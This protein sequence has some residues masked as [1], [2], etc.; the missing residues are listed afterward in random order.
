MRK[1]KIIMTMLIAA[2]SMPVM[3]QSEGGLLLEA[4]AEKKINKKLSMGVEGELRLRN[5]FK[6]VDRWSVGIGAR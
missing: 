1:Y 3:A 6:D 5:D 2:M 4:G